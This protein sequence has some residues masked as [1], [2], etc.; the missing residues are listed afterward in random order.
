MF[1]CLFIPSPLPLANFQKAT[2]MS[3]ENGT[4]MSTA[5]DY[6][7]IVDYVFTELQMKSLPSFG[8]YKST[9]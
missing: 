7:D 8:G 2:L 6:G 4:Q 9:S 1:N 3:T 5:K